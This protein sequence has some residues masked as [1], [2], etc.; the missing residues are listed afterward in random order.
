MIVLGM[1]IYILPN[2]AS[3]ISSTPLYRAVYLS[4][5]TESCLTA[6]ISAKCGID[7]SSVLRT[8]FVNAQGLDTLVDDEV[9]HQMAEGRAVKVQVT[10]VE[11]ETLSEWSSNNG[12]KD[13][14]TC[15]YELK[16]LT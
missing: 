2:T 8:T 3:S 10:E 12:M 4:E 1:C 9:V 14:K 16:L 7:P 11:N 6:A 15:G 13:V 5:R